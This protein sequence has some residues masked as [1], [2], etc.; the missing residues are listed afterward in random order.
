MPPDTA[1]SDPLIKEKQTSKGSLSAVSRPNFQVNTHSA[2][3]FLICTLLPRLN[4]V[5]KPRKPLLRS[6]IRATRP[7]GRKGKKCQ[8][9]PALPVRVRTAQSP[10]TKACDA[11]HSARCVRAWTAQIHRSNL[12]NRTW[13]RQNVQFSGLHYISWLFLF[14]LAIAEII[15]FAICMYNWNTY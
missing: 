2:R 11:E 7:G 1:M 6:I 14:N 12:R 8:A 13:L 15:P 9:H 4:S 5:W 10:K 3:F